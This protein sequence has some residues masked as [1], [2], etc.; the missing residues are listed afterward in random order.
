M[1][2]RRWRRDG[3]EAET[4][5]GLLTPAAD[6]GPEAEFAAMCPATVTVHAARVPFVAMRRG[7]DMDPTIVLEAVRAMAEP[8]G[9]D[10]AVDLLA[11]API[12]VIGFGFTSSSYVIGR[13]GE[14]E[15][16]ARAG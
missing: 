1:D 10:A 12:Q 11:L 7:G 14:M 8:P 15:M 9:V 4:R 3:W 5:I 2:D 16:C 13:D 6:V